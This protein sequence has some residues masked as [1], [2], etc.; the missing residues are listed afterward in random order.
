MSSTVTQPDNQVTD[1]KVYLNRVRLSQ[2]GYDSGGSY[3]GVG[4]PLYQFE[5]DDSREAYASEFIRADDREHAKDK[6][7]RWIRLHFPQI[8]WRFAR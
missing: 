8:A 7:A 6:A 4:Q 3:W 5:F 1:T 2:G